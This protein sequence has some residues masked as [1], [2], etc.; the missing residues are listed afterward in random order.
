MR[1]RFEEISNAQQEI[2]G[3]VRKLASGHGRAD[4]DID[5]L[6]PAPLDSV[7]KL[8]DLCEKLH[9]KDARTKLVSRR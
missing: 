3:L 6:L 5:D 2:L 1:R 8:E 7:A 9:D 4:D